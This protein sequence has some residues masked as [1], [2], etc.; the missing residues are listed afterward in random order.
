M[1][2]IGIFLLPH[3]G[4][5]PKII[6]A[7]TEIVQTKTMLSTKT[8]KSAFGNIYDGFPGKDLL[9]FVQ[10][11]FLVRRRRGCG[12]VL[13]MDCCREAEVHAKQPHT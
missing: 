13:M 10:I 2:D 7:P 1:S 11:C 8:T 3:I 4:I 9:L 5:G 12:C 6:Q